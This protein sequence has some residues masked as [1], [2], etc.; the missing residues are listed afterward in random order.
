MV[1]LKNTKEKKYFDSRELFA[2]WKTALM[3]S[4][5]MNLDSFCIY[6][7]SRQFVFFQIVNSPGECN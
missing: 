2:L 1:V 7:A 3:N 5:N 6:K 4:H